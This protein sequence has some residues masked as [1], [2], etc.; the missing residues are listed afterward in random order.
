MKTEPPRPDSIDDAGLRRARLRILRRILAA[1]EAEAAVFG[2]TPAN[3]AAHI[4]A[5]EARIAVLAKESDG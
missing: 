4:A 5:T 3:L 1:L 2:F